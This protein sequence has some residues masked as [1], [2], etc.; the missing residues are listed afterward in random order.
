[1]SRLIDMIA[2]STP[3]ASV[4]SLI[5]RR[6][7]TP[8]G[9]STIES[10]VE[11]AKDWTLARFAAAESSEFVLPPHRFELRDAGVRRCALAPGSREAES[12][13]DAVARVSTP[14]AW[15]HSTIVTLLADSETGTVAFEQEMVEVLAMEGEAVL[16]E[17]A[18]VI[19]SLDLDRASARS[20]ASSDRA[21]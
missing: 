12:P 2:G 8:T 13:L 3:I 16:V 1:M 11:T 5:P 20:T 19:P 15:S 21:G 17:A 4:R 14:T 18:T 9:T 6:N 7:G 10:L